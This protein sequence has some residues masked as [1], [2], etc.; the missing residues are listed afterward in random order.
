M[1]VLYSYSSDRVKTRSLCSNAVN[2]VYSYSSDRVFAVVLF[3]LCACVCVRRPSTR[4]DCS[5]RRSRCSRWRAAS[6]GAWCACAARGSASRRR[7]TRCSSSPALCPNCRPARP[8]P[9]AP[10]LAPQP[11]PALPLRH[12]RPQYEYSERYTMYSVLRAQS[13]VRNSVRHLR[14]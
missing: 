1:S 4:C 12:A 10:P 14:N 5:R 11:P 9:R 6:R 3:T 8:A 13:V 7:A 2:S